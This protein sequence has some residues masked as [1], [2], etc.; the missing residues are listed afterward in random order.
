MFKF[1]TKSSTIG[2]RALALQHN[3]N[4]SWHA[5]IERYAILFTKIEIHK[6]HVLP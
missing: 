3:N 5:L 6:T 2:P 4:S 1:T